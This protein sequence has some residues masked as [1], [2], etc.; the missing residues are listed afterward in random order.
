MT[1]KTIS[2][3]FLKRAGEMKFLKKALSLEI[4]ED[5]EEEQTLKKV[6]NSIN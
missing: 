6:V 3:K 5:E 4:S 1:P 2:E